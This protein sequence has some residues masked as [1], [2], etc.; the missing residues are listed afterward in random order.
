MHDVVT[1]S[2]KEALSNNPNPYH[3][4]QGYL[5]PTTALG[6]DAPDLNE[7]GL[8]RLVLGKLG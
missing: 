5:C 7:K 6:V 4:E 1:V 3:P 8:R 2:T